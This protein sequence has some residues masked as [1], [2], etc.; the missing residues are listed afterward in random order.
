M[1]KLFKINKKFII[2]NKPNNPYI[3]SAGNARWYNELGELHRED[4]PAVEF[5]DGTR[6]WLI[7]DEFHREDGPAIEDISGYNIWYYHGK[8]HRSDGPA[9]E[10]TATPENNEWYYMGLEIK[11][12]SLEE[13]QRLVKLKAFW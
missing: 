10:Y 8:L 3:D 11:C 6:Y 4:G 7:N 13:F 5:A 1:S 12:S 9:E 2:I